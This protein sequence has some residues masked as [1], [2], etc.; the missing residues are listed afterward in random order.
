MFMK[1]SRGSQFFIYLF[2][3][4]GNRR[5]SIGYICV[6]FCYYCYE[7]NGKIWSDIIIGKFLLV[8]LVMTVLPVLSLGRVQ[9][10]E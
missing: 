4:F 3:N 7:F 1:R 5:N 8:N 9:N 10:M 2:M 6:P